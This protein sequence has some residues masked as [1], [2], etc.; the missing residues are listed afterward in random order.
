[1]SW[2]PFDIRLKLN[3]CAGYTEE[4]LGATMQV[5]PP[6]PTGEPEAEPDSESDSEDDESSWRFIGSGDLGS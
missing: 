6:D 5:P 1:M 3:G 4:L 2:L